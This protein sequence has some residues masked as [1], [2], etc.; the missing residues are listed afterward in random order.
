MD[1][2][3]EGKD[4]CPVGEEWGLQR[5]ERRRISKQDEWWGKKERVNLVGAF[6]CKDQGCKGGCGQVAEPPPGL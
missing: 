2:C 6:G 4:I 1:S 5:K 3:E